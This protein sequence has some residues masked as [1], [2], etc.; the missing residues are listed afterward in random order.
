M[1]EEGKCQIDVLI[2]SERVKGAAAK[3]FPIK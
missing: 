1:E 2:V 3:L